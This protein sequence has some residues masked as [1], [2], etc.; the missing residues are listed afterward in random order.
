[1]AKDKKIISSKNKLNPA[2]LFGFCILIGGI[3][4][5]FGT[6]LATTNLFNQSNEFLL[7][8]KNYFSIFI[9]FVVP[10][11]II[12]FYAYT[13]NNDTSDTL[14]IEQKADSVYYM[15]F[16][17]TLFAM[18]AS[19]VALSANEEIRFNAIVVN[20]GL[21][22]MTTILG[23][24]IRIMW[25]QLS[26]Q[27]LADAESILRDRI[28]RRSQDLQDQTEK[29]VASITALSN[30]LTDVSEPLKVSFDK[31]INNLDINEDISKKLEVLDRSA[32]SAAQS[33]RII[34]NLAERLDISVSMLQNNIN[35]DVINN[36]TDLSTSVSTANPKIVKME[37]E[38]SDKIENIQ[39]S[40][41][42]LQE[43]IKKTDEIVLNS[44][45]T[46]EKK[47]SFRNRF[48]NRF[49]NLFKRKS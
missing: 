29:V 17:L 46:I 5:I 19:L 23:L 39:D 2:Q 36:V 13:V 4:I 25:L 3:C 6:W 32:D 30:Q 28:I 43:S 12:L 21:A 14:S 7:F 48:K 16:I 31:L 11:I 41:V 33:L 22:L 34:A 35:T 26:S 47:N 20:F 15:G 49:K 8:I 27:N 37:N 10:L 18:T 40:L 44:Q 9:N 38:L 42:N 24:A 45:A 1:M